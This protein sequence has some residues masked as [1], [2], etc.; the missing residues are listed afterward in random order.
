MIINNSY[1]RD[2]IFSYCDSQTLHIISKLVPHTSI[3]INEIKHKRLKNGIPW[4]VYHDNGVFIESYGTGKLDF[5]LGC[6]LPSVS[7]NY[8]TPT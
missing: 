6:R 2:I 3:I 8:K 7:L 1:I 5:I 4:R